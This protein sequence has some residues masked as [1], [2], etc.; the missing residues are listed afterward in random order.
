[1]LKSIRSKLTLLLVSVF[2]LLL[3]SFASIVYFSMNSLL[4]T[5]F[6]KIL[7]NGAKN[8][9]YIVFSRGP[10]KKLSQWF[11][12]GLKDILT[13]SQI[14]EAEKVLEKMR[15]RR[16]L[17]EV[18]DEIMD[19]VFFFQPVYAQVDKLAQGMDTPLPAIELIARSASLNG[20][21]LAMDE[22]TY[23]RLL[24][25]KPHYRM[26]RLGEMSPT[27]VVSLL[28]QDRENNFFILQVG[29]TSNEVHALVKRIR[30][31]IAL[32]VPVVLV[33]VAIGGYLFV[34]R[35][36]RP[37]DRIVTT[38]NSITSEDL[39]LRVEPSGSHDEIG[40]L[41][42][43]FNNMI[44]RLETSFKSIKEFA[45]N[46][47]HELKTPLTVIRGEIEV[48]LRK[49]RNAGDY[50]D[51]LVTLNKETSN[52]QAIVDD[53][54]LLSRID[55]GSVSFSLGEISLD[56]TLLDAYE[57]NCKP[58]D[59]KG[60]KIILK[61]IDPVII[62]GNR[63]LLR[64]MFANLLQNAVKYTEAGGTIEIELAAREKAVN[65]VISDTGIGIPQSDL[66]RVFDSFFRV[67]H[68]R[69]D[70]QTETGGAG[71][72]L[73]IVKRI[74]ELHNGDISV[75]SKTGEGT[76]FSITF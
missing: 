53:L 56:E 44:H 15:K 29:M 48:A 67:T 45:G 31:F 47:S 13:Q 60:I 58:A 17:R 36:F 23:R 32:I 72:G 33:L 20:H 4:L 61:N 22:G 21:P 52:L 70:G 14:D 62:K 69:F 39:S 25:G 55:A 12:R 46:A 51:V 63:T 49:D 6:D 71:L 27:R 54:L 11:R 57:E 7:L 3:I 50:R 76:S 73:T 16:P 35:A 40:R 59:E 24:K 42:E 38:V 41:T 66:P 43:T 64:R 2:G 5:T 74:V 37:V 30:L 65:C 26:L 75:K 10:Q 8:L 68:T 18:L 1:M 28:V 34:R 19:R 9:E